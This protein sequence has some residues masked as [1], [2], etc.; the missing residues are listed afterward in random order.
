MIKR[1]IF[2][3]FLFILL[4]TLT[5]QN[6]LFEV[7]N[8]VGI[9]IFRV[10]TTGVQIFGM[11]LEAEGDNIWISDSD[12]THLLTLNGTGMVLNNSAG[13]QVMN[14]NG[15]S[16]RFYVNQLTETDRGGFAV[17]N[18]ISNNI[19]RFMDLTPENYFI[20]HRAGSST[21]TGINNTFIG[22]KS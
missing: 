16:L 20:G 13:Q 9:S 11:N 5:A 1:L 15:D 17:G 4:N 19:S 3:V 6:P 21:T 18:R 14:V 2:S 7:R 22:Y 12:G 10:T 8:E